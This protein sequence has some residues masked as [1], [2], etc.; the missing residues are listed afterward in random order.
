MMT[1][2]VGYLG[3]FSGVLAGGALGNAAAKAMGWRVKESIILGGI[4]GGG[5]GAAVAVSALY[6]EGP[7]IADDRPLNVKRSDKS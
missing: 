2:A 4:A 7:D 3:Y 5:V 1:S 6:Y